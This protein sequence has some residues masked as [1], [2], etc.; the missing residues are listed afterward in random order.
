MKR[1][2]GIIG[3]GYVGANLL[4]RLQSEQD[5]FD[6]AFVYARN[7]DALKS[8]PKAMILTDLHLAQ[9]KAPDIIVEAAHPQITHDYGE[10]F[11]EFSD[12]MPLSVTALAD[13][14]LRERLMDKAERHN[15]HLLV[16]HGA[17]VGLDSLIAWR[18]QWEDVSIT[19]R[20][21]P[22]SIDFDLIDLSPREITVETIIFDGSVR[23]VASLFPRNVNA[24]VALALATVGLDRCHARLI[25][26][27]SAKGLGLSIKARG[28]D[29]S[30]LT[31][32]RFQ[33]AIG[34][35][36]SEMF[37][38]LYRSLLLGT[39]NFHSFDFV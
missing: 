18:D 3:F 1:R 36:G 9:S 31:I 8:V 5:A 38:S 14:G 7:V 22:H 34:V 39:E 13:D 4:Q 19:F 21:P 35:S 26:D 17:V 24:M 23:K 2:V 29:G 33:P 12:Y 10:Q 16:P 15:H 20:K 25:A 27:P 32:D 11:L 28:K 37:E 6:V 30:E